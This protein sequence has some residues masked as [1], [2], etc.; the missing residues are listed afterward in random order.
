MK[1]RWLLLLLTAV[2]ISAVLAWGFSWWSDS[3][4]KSYFQRGLEAYRA[5]EF[6]TLASQAALLKDEPGFE[7]QFHL[8]LGLVLFHSNKHREA[9]EE[10]AKS[11]GDHDTTPLA[12]AISGEILYNGGQYLDAERMLKAAV[13]VKPDMVDA[14]RYLIATYYDLGAMDNALVHI[15]RVQELAPDDIRPWRLEGLIL[16]D[17]EKYDEALAA[18]QQALLRISTVPTE[19]EIRVEAAECL[20]Q[21]RRHEEA[22][23]MLETVT[24][25]A[26]V[27]AQRTEC[28][29]ALGHDQEAETNLREGLKLSP[30][31]LR[32][33]KTEISLLQEKNMQVDA[34]NKLKF[35]IEQ[36]PFDFN[37][38]SMAM[39]AY[40]KRGE[41]ELADM[42]QVKMTELRTLKD[43]FA[44]L[45]IRAIQNPIDVESRVQLGEVAQR[46]GM[47]DAAAN[48]YKVALGMA[49]DHPL[50]TQRLQEL[51]SAPQN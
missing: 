11:L 23:K 46:L 51:L 34:V 14:H 20:I 37:L 7:P 31:D 43:Q 22:L 19:N 25:N 1:S 35:A 29:L 24:V 28:Q 17:F 4:P 41:K 32:L 39:L 8:L 5:G 26:E 13:Q 10:L 15:A 9:L 44:A 40:Q 42:Q 38:R 50:A 27:L 33:L 48:W 12:L 45:H 49:P 3:T 47:R 30:N 21:L 6:P 18:Y 16:K 36:H 2:A